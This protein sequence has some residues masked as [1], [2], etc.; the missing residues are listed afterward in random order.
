MHHRSSW[1]HPSE[2]QS[3]R[4][5]ASAADA[6]FSAARLGRHHQKLVWMSRAAFFSASL[7]A[8][9]SSRLSPSYDSRAH[10]PVPLPSS[11]TLLA[12]SARISLQL[13]II[14]EYSQLPPLSLPHSSST[15]RKVSTHHRT[16]HT[17]PLP[18]WHLLPS[19]LQ[20]QA[21]MP[22]LHAQNPAASGK[23][24]PPAVCTV[25]PHGIFKLHSFTTMSQ[26]ATNIS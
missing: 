7:Q 17:S 10:S 13:D 8:Q 6:L 16:F 12:H 26:V 3:R 1:W 19:L 2:V 11:A 5:V 9:V 20:L 4:C 24:I 15:K 23:C 25:Q 22:A 14:L 18:Q 21:V